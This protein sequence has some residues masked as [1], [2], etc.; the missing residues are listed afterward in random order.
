[1][2]IPSLQ[3]LLDKDSS[4]KPPY[5]RS[6]F[7]KY[8]TSLHCLENYEF[9]YE[10]NK[11][12][13]LKDPKDKMKKWDAIIKTFLLDDSSKEINLPHQL[14]KSLLVKLP[15]SDSLKKSYKVIYELLLDSY[16]QFINTTRKQ[17]MSSF[18]NHQS[19]SLPIPVGRGSISVSSSST[20]SRRNS[21]VDMHNNSRKGS[22]SSSNLQSGFLT[23][24]NSIHTSS[25]ST[26]N[27]GSRRPSI[28]TDYPKSPINN[29]TTIKSNIVKLP[30]PQYEYEK[31][32]VISNSTQQLL[33]FKKKFK[34]RRNSDES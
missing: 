9:I 25:K 15:S 10:V 27:S 28:S 34:F 22:S 12:N 14:K 8:L 17:N 23:R 7:I 6:N 33:L 24:S 11:F 3:D 16:N 19:H 2:S 32:K 31:K 30:S 1:M 4:H 20:N 18:T 26:P 5:S 21:L 29:G 13:H